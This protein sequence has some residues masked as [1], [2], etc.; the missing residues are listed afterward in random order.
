MYPVAGTHLAA[1]HTVGAHHIGPDAAGQETGQ[2]HLRTRLGDQVGVGRTVAAGHRM[3][4]VCRTVAAA[5]AHRI[6]GVVGRT[7]MGRHHRRRRTA[8]AEG[9]WSPHLCCHT[10][11][12]LVFFGYI[13]ECRYILSCRCFR[14]EVWCTRAPLSRSNPLP[15]IRQIPSRSLQWLTAVICGLDDIHTGCAVNQSTNGLVLVKLQQEFLGAFIVSDLRNLERD[16]FIT[17]EISKLSTVKI[18]RTEL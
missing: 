9:L 8:R 1:D 15:S 16:D 18:L 14:G 7:G 5:A 2:E 17:K 12:G 13:Q 11:C 10:V 4:A 3:A 6:V